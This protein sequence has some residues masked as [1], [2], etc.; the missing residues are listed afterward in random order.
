MVNALI[1]R[2]YTIIGSEIHIDIY[3]DRIE[4]Y[5][6]GGMIDGSIIQ[7]QGLYQISSKRRNP[8][9]ADI[10][11]RIN[12]M[13]RR[14]SGFKKILNSYKIQKNYTKNLKPQFYSNES[15]FF[16][17]L[18]NLNYNSDTTTTTSSD[19]VAIK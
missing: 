6:P 18:K 10:F 17:I 3:D 19:K 13:E 12:L 9:I 4:I 15:S 5:S 7:E 14:G 2:D 1:H 8:L 11:S 16:I